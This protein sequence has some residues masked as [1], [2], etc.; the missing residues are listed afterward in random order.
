M[1]KFNLKTIRFFIVVILALNL[2]FFVLSKIGFLHIANL[3]TLDLLDMLSYRIKPISK[4]IDDIVIIAI[5]DRSAEVLSKRLPWDRTAFVELISVLSNYKPKV[6]ALDVAFVGESR[7]PLIDEAFVYILKETGNVIIASHFSPKGEYIKPLNVLAQAAAGYGFINKPRDRDSVVRSARAAIY[8]NKKKQVLDYSFEIKIL[9]KFLGLPLDK[10]MLK[11]NKILLRKDDDSVVKSIPI[12]PNGVIPIKYRARYN[13]FKEIPIY[14]VLLEDFPKNALDNKIVMVGLTTEIHHDIYPTPLG[15]MP[16]SAINT[17]ELMMFLDNDFVN[18]LP[19]AVEFM[20]FLLLGL[21]TAFYTYRFSPLKGFFISFVQI[22]LISALT[23]ILFFENRNARYFDWIFAIL[24]TSLGVNLYKYLQL[25]VESIAL[26]TQAITDGLTGLFVFRYFKLRLQSEW[27]KANMTNQKLTLVMADI[28]HFKQ[29]N[30][31]YGHNAG[32][33]V[34]KQVAQILLG[35]S[36]KSDVV[37]RYGGEEFAIIMTNTPTQNALIYTERVRK[38]IENT[39]FLQ[40][41]GV[42]KVTISLGVATYPDHNSVSYEQL[43]ESADK[44]LYQAKENGRNQSCV[45]PNKNPES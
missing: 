29:I 5:D 12:K 27:D 39:D 14:K 1:N 17:N 22:I 40:L 28:D 3:K 45:F 21:F 34:L 42:N 7:E 38:A 36:R 31:T 19:R 4:S 2:Y 15:I 33:A 10:I 6:I 20:V 25:I 11:D 37:C 18:E 44:A 24:A 35:N 13:N 41:C 43:I 16:G 23:L 8:E 26:K 30:D 9:A 32:N